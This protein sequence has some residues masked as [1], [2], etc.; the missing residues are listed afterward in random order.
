MPKT[1]RFFLR[2]ELFFQEK[3]NYNTKIAQFEKIQKPWLSKGGFLSESTDAFVISSNTQ[4]F[5]FP[6]FEFL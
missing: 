1:V 2:T 5:Y 3:V 4:T 6:E